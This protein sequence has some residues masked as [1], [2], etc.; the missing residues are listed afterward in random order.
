[1]KHIIIKGD[2]MKMVH[3][4]EN[5]FYGAGIDKTH[6]VD[7]I[8][9]KDKTLCG[10]TWW[11]FGGSYSQQSILE[12]IRFKSNGEFDYVDCKKC[13]KKYNNLRLKNVV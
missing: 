11:R 4:Y 9:N 6:L 7:E 12:E 2:I 10:R 8:K 13:L 1:M 3:K 5:V